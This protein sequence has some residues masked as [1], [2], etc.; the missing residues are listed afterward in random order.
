MSPPSPAPTIRRR[1]ASQRLAGKPL[2]SVADA[3]RWSGAVQ[4]QEFDEVKW[5]LSQR[6]A[7]EPTDAEVQRAHDEGKVLRTH[8]MRP[9]WHLVAAEDLR[10]LLRLTAPR[11]NQANRYWYKRSGLDART[12]GRA[13]DVIARELDG[14]GSRTRKELVAAL[15][16]AGIE[17]D[18][19]RLGYIFGHAE[20]EQMICSGPR[21]GAWH[22]YALF[23]ERVPAGEGPSGDAALAE[24]ATRYFRS[25][26]PATPRDFSWWSGLTLTQA[27]A[28][29]ELCAPALEREDGD[30]GTP[31]Y[32]FGAAE[33]PARHRCL[34]LP[35]YDE[36]IVAY[37]DLR[38]DLVA[39]PPREGLLTR[40]IAIDGRTVGGWK[41]TLSG[42]AVTV[43]AVVFAP[44][45][46]AQRAALED[47]TARFGAFLGRDAKLELRLA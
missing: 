28:A 6:I 21:R 22:T 1:H 31:W 16:S 13:H 38:V 27:R 40:T 34:L 36:L 9:T 10:W 19:L 25:H 4:G 15:G 8:A 47:A 14:G 43:E 12:L 44:L 37:K 18:S 5:S 42:D 23:D 11:V 2:A 32:A 29:I 17:G 41:R 39:Q 3:V 46:R 20:L 26:G 45:T 24:L 7:G 33:A 35:T 30:D